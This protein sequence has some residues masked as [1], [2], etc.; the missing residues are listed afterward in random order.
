M[1][2]IIGRDKKCKYIDKLNNK[3]DRF[4]AS[5]IAMMGNNRVITNRFNVV[6]LKFRF[7]N[8]INRF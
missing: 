4:F 5:L 7:L 3:V 8:F 1:K 2:I 6:S